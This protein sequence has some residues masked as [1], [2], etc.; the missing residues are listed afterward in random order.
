[1]A[2]GKAPHMAG[3]CGKWKLS[4]YVSWEAKTEEEET[5]VIGVPPM[6]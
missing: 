4:P 6:T 3:G 2:Y 5:Q 1:L